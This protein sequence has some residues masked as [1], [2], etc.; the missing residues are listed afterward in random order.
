[1]SSGP[2][3]RRGAESIV[4]LAAA[5]GLLVLH[6]HAGTPFALHLRVLAAL[7]G[8]LAC[9]L[10]WRYFAAGELDRFPFLPYAVTQLYLYWGFATIALGPGGMPTLGASAWTGAVLGA[11]V[12]AI[13]LTLAFPI[14]REL[15]DRAARALDR[16]LPRSAPG[17]SPLVLVPWL[18]VCALVHAD[19]VADV[20]P[21]SGYYVMRTLG[22]YSP[23]LAA[24]AWRDLRAG[25]RSW[26]LALCAGA[27]SLAGL[28]SGMLEAAVQPVLAAAVLY[29][30]FQRRIPWRLVVAGAVIVVV[31]NP[32]KHHYR[33]IAW[34]DAERRDERAAK[35]PLLAAE[36]W[37]A[38]IRAAWTEDPAERRRNTSG[39]A[40]RLDELSLNALVLQATPAAVPFDRGVTWPSA[41]LSFVPRFLFP[42]KPSYTE[43]YND[44]F[45]VTFGLQTRES[46]A[47][48][49][50]AFPLVADGYWNF[51]WPG[52]VFVGIATGWVIGFFAGAFRP[53]S[54]ALTAIAAS[55]F[56]QLHANNP[57]AL[58]V[59]GV[60]QRLVGLGLVI[61]IAWA[62]SLAVE[63]TASALRRP[64]H[65]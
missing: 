4:L 6:A 29:V 59:I 8:A 10:W 42:G 65:G 33:E 45:N 15:G 21:S 52:V 39:L 48:S 26:A 47:T 22:D 16:C 64:V 62:V 46:T 36:R 35:D 38:A 58:Q 7:P 57:L 49:T 43:L 41:L 2:E 28:L 40:S 53:R 37:G 61:W 50:G 11:L 23:L 44:R 12:V 32:A 17:L 27:L 13:G 63:Q 51:G 14:G 19:V 5:V 3:S 55:T 20:V 18:A 30:V 9:L 54:W 31:V 24:I 1:M 25:T 56:I 34:E 60:V